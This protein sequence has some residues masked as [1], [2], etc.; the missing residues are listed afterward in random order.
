MVIMMAREELTQA[1][2]NKN[3]K[4]VL[5]LLSLHPE[6]ITEPLYEGCPSYSQFLISQRICPSDAVFL[7]YL[8]QIHIL[9]EQA[10]KKVKLT[11]AEIIQIENR[12]LWS[13]VVSETDKMN[14]VYKQQHQTEQQIIARLKKLGY[15]HNPQIVYQSCIEYLKTNTALVMSFNASFLKNQ[16]L[17]HYQAINMFEKKKDSRGTAYYNSRDATEKELFNFLSPAIYSKLVHSLGSRPRYAALLL[18]DT[19]HAIE[20]IAGYGT[21]FLVLHNTIKFNSLFNSFDSMNARSLNKPVTPC[22]FHHLELLLFQATDRLLSALSERA[23]KGVLPSQYSSQYNTYLNESY[24]EVMLPAINLLDPA[25]V[26]HIHFNDNEYKIPAPE[27]KLL[28]SRGITVTQGFNSPYIKITHEFIKF[29]ENGDTKNCKKLIKSY[30][31][32]VS[33]TND[34]GEE[35]MHIAVRQGNTKLVKFLVN[36]GASPH[37]LTITGKTPLR[38]AA[39]MNNLNLVEYLSSMPSPCL[40]DDAWFLAIY[41]ENLEQAEILYRKNP[42]QFLD[43]KLI[44]PTNTLLY[45]AIKANKPIEFIE[46]LCECGFSIT[47][48]YYE[49]KSP[50]DLALQSRPNLQVHALIT[51]HM[52]NLSEE[53]F[54][55]AFNTLMQHQE[56]DLADILLK[57]YPAKINLLLL[58]AI[59]AKNQKFC[60]ELLVQSAN[61]VY[62]KDQALELAIINELEIVVDAMLDM[63]LESKTLELT[64]QFL[65]REP[66]DKYLSYIKKIMQKKSDLDLN[67]FY[68]I[69]TKNSLLHWAILTRKNTEIIELL[70]QHGANTTQVNRTQK[71]PI[72]LAVE[73]GHFEALII[74]LKYKMARANSKTLLGILSWNE[75]ENLLHKQKWQNQELFL[76]L[77]NHQQLAMGRSAEALELIKTHA[78]GC[79]IYLMNDHSNSKAANLRRIFLQRSL[80]EQKSSKEELQIEVRDYIK[81]S[82]VYSQNCLGIAF[83]GQEARMAFVYNLGFFNRLSGKTYI[84]FEK[85]SKKERKQVISNYYNTLLAR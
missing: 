37:R 39:E 71:S 29:V 79:F 24:I 25:C 41:Q 70:C 68:S 4:R 45:H 21:S 69:E 46:F 48:V 10:P 81:G 77:I 64:L 20:P 3:S 30:P 22:T 6:L 11:Q 19:H 53:M 55:K 18:L 12:K 58:E 7:D 9:L 78:L 76:F 31:S 36:K 62:P 54:R 84:P 61:S 14:D 51:R 50:L 74:L 28:E 75:F 8:E 65:I 59:S 72:D 63:K 43:P 38:L 60:L 34:Q 1:F 57:R 17:H 16:D 33:A 32:L 82:G 26:Q 15:T 49:E 13:D 83:G 5:D 56:T 66:S 67:K 47:Q 2:K 40:S 44:S 73:S 23:S 27:Q 80:F 52:A 85:L 35:P 42:R